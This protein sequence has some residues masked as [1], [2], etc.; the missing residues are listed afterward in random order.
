MSIHSDIPNPGS[1][2]PFLALEEM[3][4]WGINLL[5][6]L[7][8]LEFC[9]WPVAQF[10]C[11]GAICLQ[12]SKASGFH[13]QRFVCDLSLAMVM[14]WLSLW[15]KDLPTEI[16]L[17]G[18]GTFG[19][20]LREKKQS[21]ERIRNFDWTVANSSPTPHVALGMAWPSGW[22]KGE[23]QSSNGHLIRAALGRKYVNLAR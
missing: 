23:N 5:W 10:F 2:V 4:S 19:T 22:V 17:E 18:E 1:K 21:A 15:Y 8:A 3:S 12:Q 13:Q 14:C 7:S 20:N 6:V 11:L 9:Q 16:L